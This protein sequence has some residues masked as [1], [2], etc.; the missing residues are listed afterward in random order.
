MT[1]ETPRRITKQEE[2]KVKPY[3]TPKYLSSSFRFEWLDISAKQ[4]FMVWV[5]W[6]KSSSFDFGFKSLKIIKTWLGELI[7]FLTE[8]VVVKL[9]KLWSEYIDKFFHEIIPKD[10]VILEQPWKWCC[11][12]IHNVRHLEKDK[13][14]WL[15][16]QYNRICKPCWANKQ[17]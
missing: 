12:H 16:A 7:W 3:L 17:K 6:A 13:Y 8:Q 5:K 14:G 10:D 11:A 9:Q 4:V 15:G 2:Q 1:I